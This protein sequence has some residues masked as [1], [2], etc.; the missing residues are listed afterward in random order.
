MPEGCELAFALSEETFTLR[1]KGQDEDTQLKRRDLRQKNSFL[2][3][4]IR[5]M[6]F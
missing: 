4:H 3:S 1:I 6:C 2:S 5:A